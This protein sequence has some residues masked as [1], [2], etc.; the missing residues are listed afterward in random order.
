MYLSHTHSP[1]TP[2]PCYLVPPQQ[3]SAS[4]VVSVS[5]VERNTFISVFLLSV[6]VLFFSEWTDV[7]ACR[8]AEVHAGIVLPFGDGLW[9]RERTSKVGFNMIEIRR[10]VW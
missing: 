8:E 2:A 1:S 7:E 5:P 6:L 9:E 3:S 10:K 4:S